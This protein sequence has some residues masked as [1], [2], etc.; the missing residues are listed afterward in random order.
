MGI[1]HLGREAKAHGANSRADE[2]HS[3]YCGSGLGDKIRELGN[4]IRMGL[5]SFGVKQ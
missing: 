5:Y 4:K 2:Q 3:G 1:G